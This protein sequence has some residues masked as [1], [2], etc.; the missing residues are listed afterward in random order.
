MAER[1]LNLA[2]PGNPRY[3]PKILQEIYGYDNLYRPLIEVELALLDELAAT[4]IMPAKDYALLTLKLREDLLLI[5]T[6][7]VDKIEA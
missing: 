1:N 6:T 2:L 5:T 3:Q 7:E 4:G